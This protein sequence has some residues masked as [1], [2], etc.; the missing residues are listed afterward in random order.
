VPNQLTDPGYVKLG[1]T[2]AKPA[3]GEAVEEGVVNEI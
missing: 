3:V 1:L 2:F